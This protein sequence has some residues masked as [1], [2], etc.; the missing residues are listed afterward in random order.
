M[1]WFQDGAK[2]LVSGPVGP[3]EKHGIWVISVIGVSLHKLRD[4]ARWAD[5][6]PDGSRIAFSDTNTKDLWVMNAD[7]SQARPFLKP[8]GGD[9]LYYP[10]WFP[11]GRRLLYTRFREE[12]GQAH[13]VLESRNSEGNDPVVL[14][15]NP[16]VRAACWAQPGRLILGVHEAPPN[17]Q[18]MN[19]WEIGYDVQTGKPS[20]KE[21]RLTDWAGYRFSD[22]KTTADGKSLVFLNLHLLSNVYVGK[23]GASGSTMEPP[24]SLTLNQRKNW[25][26]GWASD[27]RSLLFYSDLG[28]GAFDVYRQ[29]VDQ[30]SPEKLTSGPDDKWAPQ[31]SPDGKWVLYISWPKPT[32]ASELPPGKLMRISASGGP[33]EF[34]ADVKGHT[35]VGSTQ[36]GFPSFRCP[37][38]AGADC[39]LAE[40]DG[41]KQI[42]FTSFDPAAGRKSEI[43]KFAGDPDDLSWDL[44]PDGSQVAVAT[45]DYKAAD[46]QM[47]P[48]KGGNPQKLSAMPWNE[49]VAVTWSADGKALFLSSDS[50]RGSSVIRVGPGKPPELLWKTPWTVYQLVPSPDGHYLAIGPDIADANAWI[51]PNFPPR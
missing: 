2:L 4:D 11:N 32:G 39:V 19:L 10:M 51:I 18:D 24:Q 45:F 28:G 8:D 36:G 48:V 47:L 14:V 23:L 7:G 33:A 42:V 26:S 38:R 20:G 44:S 9:R 17:Q 13:V 6:S 31:L 5:I 16:N 46:I 49:L 34:V 15:S 35:F 22:I 43:T 3:Q 41:D 21:R 29:G 40:K 1:E 25:V 37:V 50:S 27:S 12:N 30:H